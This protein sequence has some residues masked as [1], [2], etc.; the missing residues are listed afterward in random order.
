MV[1]SKLIEAFRQQKSVCTD[2]RKI[3]AGDVFF[4]LKGPNFNGNQF[5]AKA[6]ESG[7]SYAVV[8]E[9][10][11][12]NESD[13]RFILVD[14]VLSA[15]QALG[16][17]IRREWD[18]PV[19]AITGTNGKTTTKELCQ[20]VLS[21]EKKVWAT[22]GN[23]NNHIGVPL[24]LLAK[25]DDVDVIVVEMG[26][27]KMGD[28]KELCEIGEPNLAMITNIGQAHLERF[29]DVDGVQKTKGEMFD[30]IRATGGCALV[31]LGDLRVAKTAE[32][33]ECRKTFGSAGSDLRLMD[34]KLSLTGT[35]VTVRYKDWADP[36]TFQ[37]SL[38][39]AHNVWNI[40]AAILCGIELGISIEGIRKGLASYVP[41]NNRTQLVEKEGYNLMMDA[42]NANPSSMRAAI[43][44]CHAQESGNIALVLGDMFELGPNSREMH[45]ELG[46]Y[47]NE[48]KD[49]VTVLVA[50]GH[51][52]QATFQNADI[53]HKL[54][55]LEIE[56][57]AAFL[58]EHL[59]HIDL[60]LLKGSRG[61]ALERIL[62]LLE[63]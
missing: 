8:D 30:F 16:R 22:Q 38:M 47:I 26:A 27:N 39:G 49:R 56:A 57:A 14:D 51:D 24:T 60:V 15:L 10:E 44:S 61:M 55:T 4:A 6:L 17:E 7:A 32:G 50:V 5:A 33:I 59:P 54:H 25:P 37:S 35:E 53:Q 9:V 45:G 62:P 34:Q 20:A 21:T 46:T 28:I 40:L 31:N 48:F 13:E 12:V 23:L 19:F 3:K 41:S 29:G 58:K 43:H 42:Y 2:T 63:A 52:M 36:Q 11:Y 18:I 1:N